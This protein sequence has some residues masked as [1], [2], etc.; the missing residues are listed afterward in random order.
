MNETLIEP[1]SEFADKPVTVSAGDW[2]ER[3]AA[4][5]AHPAGL[6]LCRLIL[7]AVFIWASYDKILHPAEFARTIAN[8]KFL[9]APLLINLS[10]VFVPWLELLAGLMLILGIWRRGALLILTGLLA[11][12][13]ILITVTTLRGIDIACGCFGSD[14]SSRVGWGLLG[15]DL[16][17]FIP[18][19]WLWWGFRRHN[20]R[21]N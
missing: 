9:T 4:L 14:E 11:F 17:L 20:P 19:A 10:A 15:R 2:K 18:A 13:A 5:M 12:F 21:K 3:L 6:L 7:G 16:A 8:Y 1:K